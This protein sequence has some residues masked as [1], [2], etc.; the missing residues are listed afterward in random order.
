MPEDVNNGSDSGDDL[1]VLAGVV[2]LVSLAL[3][4]TALWS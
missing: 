2:A 4:A 3:L 1:N